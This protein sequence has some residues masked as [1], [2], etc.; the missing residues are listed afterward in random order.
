MNANTGCLPR[1]SK[2]MRSFSEWHTLVMN[3]GVI[4]FLRKWIR[5]RHGENI[6]YI[7]TR[8]QS[9]ILE[10][11]LPES[12]PIHAPSIS[13]DVP[14]IC[15]LNWVGTLRLKDVVNQFRE[16]LEKLQEFWSVLD[17]IDNTLSVVQPRYPSRASSSRQIH[18]G[19]DCSIVVSI[20][21]HNPRSLP[22]CRFLGWNSL[23]DLLRK[24]WRRNRK[25]WMKDIP[26]TENLANVLGMS[27]PKPECV[28]NQQHQT[29]CGIC[30]AQY[31]PVD[32][33]LGSKS[34]STPDYT[35]E[36]SSCS[37]A[38][39]S[40]CLGDWLRSITITR[41]SFDVLFGNCPYCSGP[42]AIKVNP[43]K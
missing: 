29:E 1:A 20:T 42:V 33:E 41:Q 43:D 5:D 36:N 30:Y 13:A 4:P 8:R 38:F 27:L 39:H 14:Y 22:E 7:D 9:H 11:H 26:F 32:E 31:L 18:L 34:G 15:E 24:T 16:H 6:A 28:Q 2:K 37:T 10:I 12:Y 17:N 21:V 19:N 23:S 25:Q 35:C 3:R 40:V